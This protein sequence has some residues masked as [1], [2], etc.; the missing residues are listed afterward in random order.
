MKVED[1]HPYFHFAYACMHEGT[2]TT[3][4]VSLGMGE[5]LEK[6]AKKHGISKE[7]IASRI[8]E[9]AATN[10]V[11]AENWEEAKEK[12]NRKTSLEDEAQAKEEKAQ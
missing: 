10:G 4:N 11:R 8:I 3:L 1:I 12:L 9:H 6:M 7:E 5:E 2:M